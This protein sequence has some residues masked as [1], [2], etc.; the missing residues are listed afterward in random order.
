MISFFNFNRYCLSKK[1]FFHEC[2]KPYLIHIQINSFNNFLKY[3]NKN[4]S[5]KN[6]IK[7]NF[8]VINKKKDIFVKFYKISIK[9]PFYEEEY[10]IKRNIHYYSIIFINLKFYF[11]KKK[12]IYNKNYNLGYIPYMTKRGN[13][14][15]NGTNRV[16]ISQFTKCY[17]IYFFYEKKKYCKIIPYYGNWIDLYF[18]KE[19]YF[20]FD[21]KIIFFVKNLLISLGLNKNFF[22]SFFFFNIKIKI[23]KGKKK[24][25]FLINK[26]FFFCKKYKKFFCFSAKKIIDFYLGINL[27]FKKKKFFKLNL[28][29]KKFINIFL[30]NKYLFIKFIILKKKI[31]NFIVDFYKKYYFELE[32]NNFL[33]KKGK[34]LN[35]FKKIFYKKN[36]NFSLI[37]DKRLK[38]LLYNYKNVNIFTLLEIVKKYLKF[39]KF[40]ILKDNLDSL[41][42]KLVFNSGKL[43]SIKFEKSFNKIMKN[44]KYKVKNFLSINDFELLIDNSIITI[45]LRDYFCNNELS[46]FLDQNNPLSEISHLRKI[47]LV[48]NNVKKENCGFEIRDL[49]ISHYCK[50]CPIDTP[51]GHNIGLINSFSFYSKINKYSFVSTIYK[52]CFFGKIIGVMYLD[53]K[54]EKLKNIANF[55]CTIK[56]IY[57][58]IFQLP[59]LNIRYKN[60]FKKIK[61]IFIDLIEISGSQIFSL[62]ASLIPFLENNDANRCLMGSNMQRQAV[63][64]IYADNSIVGTGNELIVGNNSNYNINS[65]ISGFVLYVDNNYIIIKNKYKLFKYKIKKFIRTNQ[66][67]TITQKPIINLGNN[68]KKGD[69]LAYSNVTN[70]GEISLGKNLRVAFMSWYGYNFEDSILI[71]NKIIKENFFSSFHI[72]EYVCVLKYSENGIEIVSNDVFSQKQIEEK[73]TKF[74]IIKIGEFVSSKDVLVG[75]MCPRGKHD[76]SPEEKL[77]KIVFSDNNFNYYEQPLCLPKNIYG[78][79]LNVDD[80][81][82]YSFD[83]NVLKILDI[84]QLVYITKNLNNCFYELFF[85]YIDNIRKYLYNNTVFLKKK[86][87]VFKK[88]NI[89]ILIN[90]KCF[91][92]KNNFKLKII[93]KIIINK[94]FF[95]RKQFKISKKNIL[96]YND[97]DK[98]IIRIIKI[99]IISKKKLKIGDKMSGRHGNKGVVSNIIEETN[100]PYD[101][102]GNQIELIL[103]PLGIPSRMN[104][105]QLIEV[106]IGSAIQEIKFFFEKINFL[107]FSFYKIKMILKLIIKIIFNKNIETFFLNNKDCYL[108]YLKFKKKISVCV[109]NFKNLEDIIIKNIINKIS[110]SKNGKTLLF[111]G[112]TGI[113]Y[114]KFI[115]VGS[116]YFMK[117]N[118]LVSDKMYSR[119]IGPYSII[120]QQPLGGKSNFGGQR[121]GEM[122]V[123]ALEAYGAAYTLKEMLTVKSDDLIGRT[124]VYKNIMN[125]IPHVDSGIPESFQ[126]LIKEIQSLC[127][128]IK[129]V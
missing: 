101:K 76:F 70:N 124:I 8:P 29:N 30:F 116:I 39:L 129:I 80:F 31:E 24:K 46:Q 118:H 19:F 107:N 99:K 40:D 10:C 32:D 100:M 20:V 63:P 85:W 59:F 50:I 75:K 60:N 122:E 72:Y 109:H 87:F 65:D 12:K 61:F 41:E 88:N 97:F 1:N 71:S 15:I 94:I 103:N 77:F 106:Y 86:I 49:H 21:K 110:F 128:D 78:T 54:R 105:G 18:D 126:I 37:G 33:N 6:I 108:L 13:F 95:K 27:Y 127:F 25:F 14:I 82:L 57:G 89:N 35:F 92:K 17:G 48:G 84:E 74:G 23:I 67:T 83:K 56:T 98:N 53:Y 117:L 68:V 58:E 9:K 11:I 66:N 114:I 38:T 51:E 7:K 111:D 96:T 16:L 79:I 73:K 42:N 91:N 62:G 44:I 45:E 104:V 2:Y 3:N 64:L 115:S 119:S 93:K 55:L 102:F 90:L 34:I 26:K 112:I 113:K 81:K 22:F 123:W 125:E 5:I 121:L 69:L 28:I 47:S 52:I 4:Y 36:F 120:T 43:L